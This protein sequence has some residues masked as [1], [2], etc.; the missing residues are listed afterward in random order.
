MSDDSAHRQLRYRRFGGGFRREDVEQAIAALEHGVRDAEQALATAQERNRELEAELKVLQGE[1]GALRAREFQVNDALAAAHRRA[2][3]LE[4]SAEARA[5]AITA[6]A[7]EEASRIRGGA[8]L[9]VEQ[10]GKQ[11]EQLLA[12]KGKTLASVRAALNELDRALGRVERGET[13]PETHAS[14]ETPQ[15]PARADAPP[16]TIPAP[17]PAPAAAPAETVTPPIVASPDEPTFF[18][19][20]ALDVGPLIDFGGLS[21]FERSLARLPNLEDVYVRRYSNDRAVIELTL[22][23][24]TPLLAAMRAT[25]PYRFEVEMLGGDAIRM[26][27]LSEIAEIR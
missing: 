27:L 25:L 15:E 13:E 21:T 12:L 19:R 4:E 3:E 20:V 7:E 24:E 10:T 26:M 22:S 9:Q 18:G 1:V 16:A 2:S 11:L 14:G 5:R 23:A 8:H 6:R 17:P